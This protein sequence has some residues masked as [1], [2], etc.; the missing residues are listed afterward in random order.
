MEI[1]QEKQNCTKTG[2]KSSRTNN[3]FHTPHLP[4]EAHHGI[5]WVSKIIFV[6]GRCSMALTSPIILGSH[7]NVGFIFTASESGLSEHSCREPNPTTHCLTLAIVWNGGERFPGFLYDAS[8]MSAKPVSH[9]WCCQVLLSSQDG[10][11]TL[12]TKGIYAPCLLNIWR[13][14][15]VPLFLSHEPLKLHSQFMFSLFK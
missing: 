10:V 11:W 14:F 3:K 15:T 1:Q 4:F 9:E 5:I 12:W 7:W 8:F 2:P 6:L 13:H